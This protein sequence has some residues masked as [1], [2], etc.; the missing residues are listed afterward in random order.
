VSAG[1]C[2]IVVFA[3]AAALPAVAERLVLAGGRVMDPA[4]GLDE[5]RNVVVENG[6][7]VEI[8]PAE[9]PGSVVDVS[10]LVVAPGFIDLHAHGQD[11]VSSRYQAADGVTTAL[12]LEIGYFPVADWY[13]SRKG[14]ALIHYGA[15][16][17]HVAARY[18]VFTS[19]DPTDI[20]QFYEA[21]FGSPSARQRA[22]APQ[23]QQLL[24][25]L[26]Q[27]LREGALGIGFG[28]TYTP[29][30]S[31]E[32]IFRAFE[33]AARFEAPCFVHVRSASRMGDDMLA[34][35]QEVMSN[36]AATGAPL[37]IVHINSSTDESV[38]AALD[39]IRAARANGVDVTTEAYPYTAGM[40]L[41]ESAL[42]DDWKGDYADLQWAATGERLTEQTY[43]QYREQGGWVIIHGRRE[44]TNRWITQQPD[45][46]VASDGISFRNGP[47]HPR[48]AGCYT[49]V[50]GHYVREQGALDLM[51]ALRKMTILPAQRLEAIAPQMKRK[52]RVQ[53]G[54]DADLTI[55][56]PTTVL[57][58]ATYT[59]SMQ[60]A[61]GVRHVL[62]GGTF[63][64][65][66]GALVDGVA[67][68][69]PVWGRHRPPAP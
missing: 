61:T 15:T 9:T 27:G 68:G 22:S 38:Y 30:A 63:V 37:H 54:A 56:D 19:A 67:P 47:A 48:G 1:R 7:I 65:R 35:L 6:Q 21:A 60:Y 28:I 49:R 29:G 42:F 40:T 24:G 8:T 46:I 52:G 13:A 33:V 5:V 43:R 62:V 36:A 58:R 16:V 51:T 41:I 11:P 18:R 23:L 3:L 53:V 17:S 64:V 45:V 66:D 34:P 69:Q 25:L 20:W 14:A 59:D 31:H 44:P 50:L 32:E 39:L 57:D 26:E 10:G 2:L 4:S 55:F 12:D